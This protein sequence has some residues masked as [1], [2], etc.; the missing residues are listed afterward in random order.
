MKLLILITAQIENGLEVAQAWQ[1]AGAPGVTIMRSYG[2]HTLQNHVKQGDVELPPMVFSMAVA[3][4]HIIEDTEQNSLII[5]S[6]VQ[7][8]LVDELVEATS[9][10]L[11]D[12]LQPDN[13]VI[14][15]L[16]VERTVGVRDHRPSSDAGA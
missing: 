6:V 12:L 9:N 5:L 10:V 16:N 1:D 3:M 14:F 11:G 15:V 2:L 13:G 8:E 4:A 7:K